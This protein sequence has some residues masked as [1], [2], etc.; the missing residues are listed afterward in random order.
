MNQNNGTNEAVIHLQ[1][2][3]FQECTEMDQAA[4]EGCKY[5]VFLDL[6]NAKISAIL[7]IC[8][9]RAD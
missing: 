4:Y 3:T 2:A 8:G 5:F 7:R 1:P 6:R 9:H